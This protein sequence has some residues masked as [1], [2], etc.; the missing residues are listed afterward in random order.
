MLGES[1]E[2]A[3]SVAPSTAAQP[4]LPREAVE[5]AGL[6]AS[7]QTPGSPATLSTTGASAAVT[8][9][10]VAAMGA[11]T[12]AATAVAATAASAMALGVRVLGMRT[13]KSEEAEPESKE[14]AG[15]EDSSS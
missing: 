2:R 1:G 12:A 10:L 8:A 4:S 15:K 5:A 7:D 14:D 3:G 11:A 13:S 9:P 6:A